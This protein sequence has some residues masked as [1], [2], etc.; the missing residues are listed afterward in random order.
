MAVYGHE[1]RN[2]LILAAT[3]AEM[4]MRGILTANGFSNPAANGKE[5]AIN[6]N[7]YAKL[8]GP[9][10]LNDYV[11]NFPNFPDLEPIRPFS[12]WNKEDPT[13][14]LGW[15]SAYNGVK[16]NR[17]NEFPKATLAYAFAAVS[18]CVVLLTAQFGQSVFTPE[19]G[20]FAKVTVP[21]WPI[22]DMYWTIQGS[23][24]WAPKNHPDLATP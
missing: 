6:S 14:S 4:H 8:Y 17:E 1:I 9:L 21:V 24:D 22:D 3:E 23:D 15:Y 13:N 20:R 5:K 18:A 2:L 12:G 10:K 19:I 7:A 16:H 11:V